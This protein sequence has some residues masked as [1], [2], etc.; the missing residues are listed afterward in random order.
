MIIIH[1]TLA[2]IIIIR[3]NREKGEQAF[4]Y[5]NFVLLCV[6][7]RRPVLC[8]SEISISRAIQGNQ[9]ITLRVNMKNAVGRVVFDGREN[10]ESE[11]T[12]HISFDINNAA[13]RSH[14]MIY[15]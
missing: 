7:T 3:S 1:F 8:S 15:I 9:L 14:S 12:N 11:R 2:L 6:L 13:R 5:S 4:H 10:R